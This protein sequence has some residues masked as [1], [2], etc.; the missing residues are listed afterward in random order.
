MAD[1][2]MLSLRADRNLA[3]HKG[4]SFRYLACSLKLLRNPLNSKVSRRRSTMVFIT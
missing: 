2:P 4:G 1:Q 3:Y